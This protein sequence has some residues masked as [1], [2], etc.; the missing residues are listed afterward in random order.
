MDAITP[1]A[2]PGDDDEVANAGLYGAPAARRKAD[3]ATEDE[4]IR[5]IPLVEQRRA[6]DRGD[7]H[8]VTVVGDAGHHARVDALRW[9]GSRRE[10]LRRY[11]ERTEAE[12]IR[13]GNWFG[14][15]PENVAHNPAHPGIRTAERLQRAGMIVRFDLER[16]LMVTIEGDD[17]GVVSERR[18]H[19]GPIHLV[20]GRHDG[21]LQ[22]TLD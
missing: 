16:D 22:E 15:D 13:V 21:G 2:P 12:D 9:Q 18:E 11:I 7:T 19:P 3:R 1:G 10:C 4:W 17:P 8:L 14:R 5:H 20:C 6:V